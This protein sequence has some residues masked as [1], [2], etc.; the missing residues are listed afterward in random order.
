M[1]ELSDLVARV[2]ALESVLAKNCEKDDR[3]AADEVKEEDKKVEASERGSILAEIADIEARIAAEESVLPTEEEGTKKEASL[4]DP[5][6]VE[7]KITQKSLTEVVDL[8]DKGG[9]A[10]EDSMLDAAPTKYAARL[11]SASS[12]L[13]AVANYLEKT[14]RTAQALRIDKIA[15]AIDARAA[16]IEEEQEERT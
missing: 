8:R 1:S 5:N 14:G 15:D 3:K 2:A 7:E 13:D 12:R 6:G 10:T 9:L 4:V 11:R 16:A